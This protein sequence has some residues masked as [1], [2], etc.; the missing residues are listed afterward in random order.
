M[1]EWYKEF[2]FLVPQNTHIGF[3]QWDTFMPEEQDGTKGFP[4][5]TGKPWYPV[6]YD[7]I[8]FVVLL[9]A[10]TLH[11]QAYEFFHKSLGVLLFS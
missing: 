10:P 9:K 2:N 5:L 7:D 8:I 11:L 3:C 4:V 1:L 6:D